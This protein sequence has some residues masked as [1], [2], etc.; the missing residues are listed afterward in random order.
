MMKKVCG[1]LLACVALAQ[2]PATDTVKFQASTLLVVEM[3]SVK[4][5][6]G[7]IVEGLTAKDF[8]VTED[9]KPQTIQFCE[10]QRLQDGP[11]AVS[12]P[13]AAAPTGA[14]AP[15]V[16]PGAASPAA[17]SPNAAAP[18]VAAVTRNQI[19]PEKPGDIRYRDR[20]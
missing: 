15:A 14:S 7:K 3:V 4:D 8:I 2:Q 18:A 13:A 17:S 1:I 12:T 16:Q 10:F 19:M 6:N 9:G 11:G 5:K 20:R